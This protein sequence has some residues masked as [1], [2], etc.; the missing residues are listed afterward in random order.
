MKTI[1]VNVVGPGRLGDRGPPRGAGDRLAR[2]ADLVLLCVPDAA[3]SEVAATIAPGPWVA[4]VTGGTPLAALDPHG[5]GSR[6]PAADVHAR[7]RPGAARRRLGGGDGRDRRGARGR[8]RARRD[9]R[10]AAFELADDD[11]PLYHAGAAFALNYLVTLHRAA[12]PLF[13]DAGAPP[14]A[15]LPLMPRTI[16]NDFELTGPIARG[17]WATVE[18]HR[19]A[20]ARAPGARGT[21]RGARGGDAAPLKIVRT[22]ADLRA[23]LTASVGLVPTMGALHDGHARSSRRRARRAIVVASLFVNPAQFGEQADLAAYPRDEAR[24]AALAEEAGVDL[25]FAPAAARSIPPGFA[26]WVDVERARRPRGRVAAGALPRR[27]DGLLKLFNSCGPSAR[28][29]AG[30]TRSR[31]V[32]IAAWSAIWISPSRFASCRPCATPTA[33]R[34]RRATRDSLPGG[35]Q[36]EHS[37]SPAR[38]HAA[39]R[40]TTQAATQSP[41]PAAP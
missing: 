25:L 16:E 37:P 28:T 1:D 30:R 9:A 7:A 13:E 11:A 36:T 29:S 12:S 22:I 10:P 34:S 35:S 17:D 40:R 38:S 5:A 14:E 24:D 8:A 21:V 20:L 4:H 27:R 2:D 33:S 26:T 41:P 3:V 31:C 15:L 18:A 39:R 23:A 19:A 6:P 32:V